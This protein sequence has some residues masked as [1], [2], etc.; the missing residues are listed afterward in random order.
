MLKYVAIKYIIRYMNL[1]KGY[2]MK[3]VT[4]VGA[5]PQ[6]IKAAAFSKE[7]RKNNTEILVHTGQHYDKNMSAV[8]FEELNIPRPDYNLGIGSGSHGM[9]TGRMLEEIEKI[10]IKEKP[11]GVLVY[12]DTNSTLAGALA[13]SKL[14][15]PVYHVE[16]GLRSYNMDM[17]E[18]Q[19]RILTDH[20]SKLLFCPTQTAVDNLKKEGIINGVINTGDIMY[21]AVLNNID[22][23]E[24]QYGNGEWLKKLEEENNIKSS[25]F[26]TK[27]YFLATI[28]RPTN[29]D[30]PDKLK[31]IF[32]ALNQ[33]DKPVLMPLHPRTS[34]KISDL[35]LQ[36]E[37]ITIIKPVGYLLML[38]LLKYACMVITDS[39]G[40]QKEAY[41]LKT[42][43]T[44]LRDET[45][46]VETLSDGWNVLS[47][48][49]VNTLIKVINRNL[50]FTSKEQSKFFG[51]GKSSKSIV[52]IL[53]RENQKK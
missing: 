38:Y 53:E 34:S 27:K 2:F 32:E 4:I 6:F 33:S 17:P 28:H 16:A 52:E 36:L 40:L 46:W 42:P 9:Q 26:N 10:L 11:D 43:C 22:I 23:A 35:N 29:T 7:F 44:T 5:R 50:D 15:I 18:E 49:E 8:F 39:G 12:G 1:T 45:E 41:F 13:A 14:L 25:N 48:I 47:P 21:D 51:D 19:N 20:I 3:L 37:N 24:K 30:N 31:K